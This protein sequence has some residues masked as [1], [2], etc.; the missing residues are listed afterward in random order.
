[1][2]ILD[3]RKEKSEAI[4]KD[5]FIR[6]Q[7]IEEKKDLDADMV[8]LMQRRGFKSQDFYSGRDF[9]VN[10]NRLDYIHL[11]KHR[12][13]DMKYITGKRKGRYK[14]KNYP[15]HNKMLFGHANNIIRRLQFGFTE[16]VK[17]QLAG[18]L[19]DV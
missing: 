16:A 19:P 10:D 17:E 3:R 6:Q 18:N 13:V 4:L 14:K 2:N 7:L 8:S 1:M 11:P 12:F 9:R 15:V 5:Q